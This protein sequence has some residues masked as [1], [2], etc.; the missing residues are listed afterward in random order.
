MSPGLSFNN[1]ATSSVQYSLLCES[2]MFSI[3]RS[4]SLLGHDQRTNA[5][6]NTMTPMRWHFLVTHVSIRRDT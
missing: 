6:A 4:I 3:A 2:R 1:E 5:N